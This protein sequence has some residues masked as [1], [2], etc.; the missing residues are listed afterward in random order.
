M[1]RR[2]S[3]KIG[4][5]GSAAIFQDKELYGQDTTALK[6]QTIDNIPLKSAQHDRM[7]ILIDPRR[8]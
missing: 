5:I 2:E 8:C 3:V 7:K 6:K 4:S 1:D